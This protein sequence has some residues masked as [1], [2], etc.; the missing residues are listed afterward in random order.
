[1]AI[2]DWL[3]DLGLE[4]YAEAFQE[5][6][7]DLEVLPNL[8]ADDLRDLGVASVG[9]RR[10]LLQAIASLQRP[11]AERVDG[12]LA[13]M[14]RPEAE[15]RQLTV[16]FCDLVSSTALSARLDP[17]DMREVIGAYQ[18]TAACEVA[19][20]EGHVAK[21]MGDGVLAYFG[22]PKA[23]EDD[24]E[25]AVRAGL[26]LV[27]AVRAL[28]AAGRP[29]AARVGIA[30]GLVVVGDLIGEGAAQEEAVVGETPNLAARLQAQAGPGAVVISQATRRLLGGLFELDDLGPQ[31][32]KGFA[33][34]LA[35][36]RVVGEGR[37]EG[38]FE[39]LRGAQLTPLIGREHELAILLERWSWAREGEGQVVLI[40][41][42]PG[43]GKSRLVRALR[44]ELAG[45]SHVVLSHFCSPY[46]TNSALHPVI[47][48]LERAAGLGADDVPEAK[49]AKLEVLLR[50]A[51][52]QL[53]EALPLIAAL[54]GIPS[55]DRYPALNLSPQRQKQRTLEALI[56][57]LA[58]LA[59]ARLVLEV[60]EDVH[61]IDPSTLELLDML[62][63]RVR[64]LPALVVLTYRPEFVPPWSGHAHVTLLPLN[65]LGRRQGAAMALR[66][67][68]GKALPGEVMD[69]ILA[70]TDGVPLFVEELTKAVL[71]SGLLRA[72]G[73]GYEVAGPL[74]RL[75][76]PAN[77]HDSLMAR[78]DRLAP[79]KELAQ[80]GAVI[81][82]EFSHEL[83]TAIA[84][85]PPEQLETALDQL[86]A[87]EL[88]FRR[89]AP[90]EA[91]YS[92]KHALVQDAAYQS[93]LKSR[94]QILHARIAAA[95]ESNFPGTVAATPELLAQHWTAAGQGEPAVRYW[96]QAAKL[97]AGRSADSEA[98]AHLTKGLEALTL[99]PEGLERD[100]AEL[101]L[102][103]ALGT[104][105]LFLAGWVAPAAVRA[106]ARARELCDRTGNTEHLAAVLWG[107]GVVQYNS[108]DLAL[109]LETAKQALDLAEGH[110]HLGE[111]VR[112]HR[113]LGNILTHLARFKEARWHLEQT[114]IIGGGAGAET[115][116]G[117]AYDPVIT[118]RTYL[119]RC[120][121][122][123]GYPD[124]CSRLL[125]QALAEAERLVH[126]PTI[127]FVLFQTVEL[128]YE[129]RQPDLTQMALKRLVPLAREQGYA[130]W[131]GMAVALDGWVKAIEGDCDFGCGAISQGMKKYTQTLLMR[132]F[133]LGM[134]ADAHIRAGRAQQA[135]R[136][137]E[138]GLGL[139]GAKGEVLWEP[140]LH[141]LT[142]D[143]W[144]LQS[145]HRSEAEA[146]YT[147]AIEVA[148]PGRE[149]CRTP[150]RDQHR[151]AM[152]GA[153]Q[154][155]RGPRPAGAGLRMVHRGFRYSR[156]DGRE[157]L[158][159]RARLARH[160]TS[161]CWRRS[162]RR[163]APTSRRRT[164]PA[165]CSGSGRSRSG[166]Y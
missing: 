26:A 35:A 99:L 88:V 36:F 77:L 105:L 117:H 146:C 74:P 71:E 84:D 116:A 57:Q 102:Q 148:R 6:D 48:Q 107:Q 44:Q 144:L 50:Q 43:I 126:L 49:L 118:S 68:G 129:R 10:R 109:A 70:K 125:D 106:W 31:R 151:P 69:Q 75:A 157:G 154:A 76:I 163:T 140:E 86:V 65:R 122:H 13:P 81:G 142:G 134:L 159:R 89:G 62:V 3:R 94:R 166:S 37:A 80:I 9:H 139:V 4:R 54:L 82:R 29:L 19:R 115:F 45:E 55:D 78:L 52:D 34:P 93:L 165:A 104:R 150:G 24:A 96:L 30:T 127:G 92:F 158:A 39:A 112:A 119:A 90:P 100:T 1:V 123:C 66:V 131:L 47:A 91:T 63:E 22:Y 83:L 161:A 79:V 130:Q 87:S 73:D 15:R 136:S 28:D 18:N 128:G 27:Q 160:L 111:I 110:G 53:E 149:A 97:A 51:T 135:L 2:E 23:H 95:L 162:R 138:D 152:G 113:T 17:E 153:G 8:T 14:A 60:Y 164:W 67:T 103:M 155:R 42:E 101:D 46:H 132:P 61:W 124:Q 59:R 64:S 7:V 56:D 114:A 11:G 85:W 141:R 58:G 32:L 147:R 145:T 98:V 20:Y 5:N 21:Y 12:M 121:L 72:A 38:R 25:R 156:P 108:G 137:L 40:A 120:L 41:G 33:E 133:L 143:A 16:L